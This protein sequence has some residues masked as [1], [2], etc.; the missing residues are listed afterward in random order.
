MRVQTITNNITIV[1]NFLDKD[2]CHRFIAK[3]E[4]IGFNEAD[5][6]LSTGSKMIKSVRNNW[7]SRF[8]DATL[9]NHFYQQSQIFVP[10]YLNNAKVF[11]LNELFRFYKYEPG[12]RFKMHRDGVVIID[13]EKYSFFTW[14]VFLNDDFQGGYTGFEDGLH[15][16][17]QQ[18]MLLLFPHHLKHESQVV[19]YGEKYVLRSDV[20]YKKMEIE[21][22]DIS[23]MR[24]DFNLIFCEI[25][26]EVFGDFLESLG[27]E[28]VQNE[29]SAWCADYKY[30]N[31]EL[32]Q[33]I[34]FKY[35]GYPD[36]P[37]CY[38]II[39]KNHKHQLHLEQLCTKLQ[40]GYSA[41]QEQYTQFVRND[42]RQLLR[43][44]LKDRM[45]RHLW[46]MKLLCLS[47]LTNNTIT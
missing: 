12:Q 7:R 46:E 26:A 42:F 44:D 20:I 33:S 4:I 16:K 2:N 27:Y 30:K 1:E 41:N 28:I 31:Y 35:S 5:V 19:S 9:A 17:P 40:P 24:H 6:S 47:A 22:D 25:V 34:L 39:I 21:E 37:G 38:Q 23:N 45:S 15:I 43:G 36:G 11:G 3:A 8:I 32:N 13:E 18:G 14:M 10:E 29:R